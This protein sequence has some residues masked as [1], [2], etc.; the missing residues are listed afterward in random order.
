MISSNNMNESKPKN[1]LQTL[2][3]LIRLASSC[4]SSNRDDEEKLSQYDI[5]IRKKSGW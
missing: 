2:W 1:Y 4:L 5:N 3:K